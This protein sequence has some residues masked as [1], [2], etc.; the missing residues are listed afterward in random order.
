MAFAATPRLCRHAF[1]SALCF[2]VES[3][4]ALPG[5]LVGVAFAALVLWAWRKRAPSRRAMGL[6]M[7][8]ACLLAHATLLVAIHQ[9]ALRPPEGAGFALQHYGYPA[10]VVVAVMAHALMVLRWWWRRGRSP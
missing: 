1:E 9:P 3:L 7:A 10:L 8:A 2:G 5:T 6:A 4:L